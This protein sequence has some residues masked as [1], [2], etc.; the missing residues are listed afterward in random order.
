MKWLSPRMVLLSSL[1]KRHP[2]RHFEQVGHNATTLEAGKRRGTGF[3]RPAL[4]G[5]GAVFEERREV[6]FHL[7]WID[8]AGGMGLR[9]LAGGEVNFRQGSRLG[10]V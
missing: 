9:V 7:A 6:L 8:E 3:L 5:A 2:P 1:L 10:C 4:F